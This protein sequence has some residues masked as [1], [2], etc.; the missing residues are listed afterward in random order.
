MIEVFIQNT[1]II[2][3]HFFMLSK[4]F[5][6]YTLFFNKLKNSTKHFFLILKALKII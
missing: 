4:T 6:K 1:L 3:L 2:V 5:L